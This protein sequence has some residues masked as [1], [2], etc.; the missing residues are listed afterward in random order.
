MKGDYSP[1]M[2]IRHAAGWAARAFTP[3]AITAV[4]DALTFGR[5]HALSSSRIDQVI[6]YRSAF[7]AGLQYLPA[8]FTLDGLVVDVGAHVGWFT[9][10][11]RQLEP[12]ARVFAIEPGPAAS[13]ALTARFVNDPMVTIDVRALS[14]RAGTATLY[15]AQ[16]DGYTSLQRPR[17]DEIPVDHEITIETTTLDELVDG[18]V[19]LLK[20]DVQGHEISVLGGAVNTLRS[21]D[22]VIIEV[23]FKS[24]YEGDAMFGEVDAAL[25]GAGFVLAGLGEARHG[26][27]F[28]D[29]CYLRA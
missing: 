1:S 10:M 23:L 26:A 16:R 13:A 18:P 9:G 25:R 27:V 2:R 22:A 29:A 19:R 21:T 28:A 7:R 11:I 20:I 5:K 4:R 6:G 17:P 14:D 12:R 3:P 24:Q 8:G 15:V